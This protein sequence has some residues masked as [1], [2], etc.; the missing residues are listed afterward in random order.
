M[1]DKAS[2]SN[3]SILEQNLFNKSFGFS[4]SPM[5]DAEELV[6]LIHPYLE[7]GS[8]CNGWSLSV[9]SLIRVV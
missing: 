7:C 9:T 4:E 6:L 1:H 8:E 2:Y 3:H 5:A